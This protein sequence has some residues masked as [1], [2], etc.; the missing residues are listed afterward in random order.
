M[1]DVCT[2]YNFDLAKGNLK[3]RLNDL[4]QIPIE[5]LMM[6]QGK[7]MKRKAF[8]ALLEELGFKDEWRK[9]DKGDTPTIAAVTRD[10]STEAGD[11]IWESYV[12]SIQAVP[13]ISALE[14]WL[15]SF[16][17]DMGK[18]VVDYDDIMG[19]ARIKEN[20]SWSNGADGCILF[21]DGDGTFKLQQSPEKI[22][23]L[24]MGMG[25]EGENGDLK[26]FLE[27]LREELLD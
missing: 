18:I 19:L 9:N 15:L 22:E 3:K 8:I 7:I 24:P 26:K 16:A 11:K 12:N 25:K 21:D 6:V 1:K 13:L 5:S 20:H 27:S 14:N 4:D 23:P 17:K 2:L 10:L